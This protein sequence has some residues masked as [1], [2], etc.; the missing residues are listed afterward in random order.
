MQSNIQWFFQTRLAAGRRRKS[1]GEMESLEMLKCFGLPETKHET[2][3]PTRMRINFKKEG[4]LEKLRAV[5]EAYTFTC[6]CATRNFMTMAK[7]R[8]TIFS[9]HLIFVHPFMLLLLVLCLAFAWFTLD[10]SDLIRV[11]IEKCKWENW[12][13]KIDCFPS[14]P[15]L[16]H[17]MDIEKDV[18]IKQ[19]RNRKPDT[20]Q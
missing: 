7:I 5:N 6:G 20:E 19:E 10:D 3:T 15:A 13:L 16:K 14:T 1:S 11:K 4:K 9:S 8:Y 12:N 18:S 2:E 17:F